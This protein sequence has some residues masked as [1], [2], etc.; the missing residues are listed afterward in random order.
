MKINKRCSLSGVEWDTIELIEFIGL[1]YRLTATLRYRLRSPKP[2]GG[3][4]E[5]MDILEVVDRSSISSNSKFN[6]RIRQ[7]ALSRSCGSHFYL[8]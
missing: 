7:L 8:V 4:L 3:F 1:V 5:S 2:F 6:F